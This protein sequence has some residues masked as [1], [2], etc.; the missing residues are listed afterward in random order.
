[1]IQTV[2]KRKFSV[3]LDAVKTKNVQHL[4]EKMQPIKSIVIEKNP[5]KNCF[6]LEFYEIQ[7]GFRKKISS[8]CPYSISI[9]NLV[10][11]RLPV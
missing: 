6:K 1:M 9:P 5:E 7:I 4:E 2:F 11:I 3:L 10:S 8:R